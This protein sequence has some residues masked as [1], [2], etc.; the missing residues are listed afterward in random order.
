[1]NNQ[2]VVSRSEW[3]AARLA[4]LEAEKEFDR[5]RDELSR[6][7]RNLPRVKLETGYTFLSANGPMSLGELFRGRSQLIVYHFMYHP[8]W[9]TGGC[10][11]CSFL[12]DHFDGMTVHLKQRDISLV[13]VSLADIQKIEDYRQRMGWSFLWV[14][15]QG[16]SFNSDFDV[17]FSADDLPG[18]V[19]YNYRDGV[20]FPSEEAPGASV[21]QRDEEGNI[22]HTYSTYG[23]GLDR[24]IGTYHFI[25]MTPKGRDENDLPYSMAWIRRHDEYED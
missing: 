15:S 12:A 22:F 14:S 24:L 4:H 13:V 7:R 10:P 5:Q 20:E 2:K 16:N 9:E 8:S 25:D 11:S 23:R 6:A 21:F 18:G 17:S 1:M 3:L 19:R